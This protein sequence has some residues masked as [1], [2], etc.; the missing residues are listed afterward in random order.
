MSCVTVHIGIRYQA[1]KCQ[2][3]QNKVVRITCC[4][5]TK[6]QMFIAALNTHTWR[7]VDAVILYRGEITEHTFSLSL[8]GGICFVAQKV[9]KIIVWKMKEESSREKF[10]PCLL[11]H[12][13]TPGQLLCEVGV[14]MVLEW[15]ILSDTGHR[16][17]ALERCWRKGGFRRCSPIRQALGLKHTDAFKSTETCFD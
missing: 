13:H 11:S 2:Y 5:T 16:I 6:A 15:Q 9:T 3:A 7:H 8:L 14:L 17:P 1:L 4:P 10:K 12:L